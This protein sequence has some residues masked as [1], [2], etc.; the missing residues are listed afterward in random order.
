[1][2]ASTSLVTP[3]PVAIK[4]LPW[5]RRLTFV[6]PKAARLLTLFSYESLH[7]WAFI[8]SHCAIAQFCEYPGYVLVEGRKSL[9]TFWVKGPRHQQFLVLEDDI[10]LEAEHPERV[11]SFPEAEVFFV[12]QSWLTPHRQWIE[13]WQRINPYIAANA[14]FITPQ[15]L[16]AA[17]RLL[18]RPMALLDAEHELQR[19]MEQQLA[20]TAIFML[21]HRGQLASE[22]LITKPLSGTTIFH[23]SAVGPHRNLP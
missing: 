11:P 6:S 19:Q 21:L 5:M 7:L 8:E 16:D 23:A 9:A 1:M 22:D 17:A 18:V 10:H 14:R 3:S 2:P 4:R 12:T 13:N 15:M 20:R